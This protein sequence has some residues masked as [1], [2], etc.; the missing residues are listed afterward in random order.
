MKAACGNAF[1]RSIHLQM[2]HYIKKVRAAA[3]FISLCEFENFCRQ[4]ALLQQ[5]R[6]FQADFV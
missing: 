5:E 4:A 2:M 1:R 3:Y 6:V